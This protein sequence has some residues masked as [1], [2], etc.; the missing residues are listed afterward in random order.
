MVPKLGD[1]PLFR[2]G[3]S[4]T[5]MQVGGGSQLAMRLLS[6]LLEKRCVNPCQV[7]SQDACLSQNLRPRQDS[8]EEQPF[9]PTNIEK[10]YLV[11]TYPGSLTHK[12]MQGNTFTFCQDAKCV[13]AC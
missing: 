4:L 12:K 2:M 3:C 13:G 11:N 1:T 6:A 9:P 8:R 5:S 10:K 7:E